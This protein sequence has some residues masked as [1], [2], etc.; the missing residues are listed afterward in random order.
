MIVDVHKLTREMDVSDVR[1][2]TL[3]DVLTAQRASGL[4]FGIEEFER[5][6]PSPLVS[7]KRSR[8]TVMASD[9]VNTD[10][11]DGA[12]FCFT[13]IQQGG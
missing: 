7:R 13:D 12:H 8:L 4:Q 1:P 10:D 5:R 9:R 2:M 3:G 11:R 6:Y